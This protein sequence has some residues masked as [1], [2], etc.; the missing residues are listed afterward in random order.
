MCC[1]AEFQ[2]QSGQPFRIILGSH[3]SKHVSGGDHRSDQPL[4]RIAKRDVPPCVTEM[5]VAQIAFWIWRSSSAS[6]TEGRQEIPGKE[7][8]ASDVDRGVLCAGAVEIIAT[9]Q[10]TGVMENH[11]CDGQVPNPVVFRDAMTELCRCAASSSATA[12]VACIV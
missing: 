8:T 9:F 10:V 11:G 5:A 3:L 4:A 7:T 1:F 6:E 2:I 12:A